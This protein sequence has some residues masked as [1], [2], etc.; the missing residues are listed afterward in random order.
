MMLPNDTALRVHF[1]LAEK[2][3]T[4]KPDGACNVVNDTTQVRQQKSN[5][6]D[7][8]QHDN[9]TH[10]VHVVAMYTTVYDKCCGR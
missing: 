4:V 2:M 6:D 5:I 7:E 3:T 8:I 10:H 1:S 9:A